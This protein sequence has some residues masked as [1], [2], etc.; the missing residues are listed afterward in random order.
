MQ[1]DCNNKH[2]VLV[3]NSID[4]LTKKQGKEI[5]NFDIVVRFGKGVP[6]GREE[7]IGSRTDIWATGS[8]RSKMR[9]HYPEDTKVLYNPSCFTY[10]E[11]YPH[12]EHTVMF[13]PDEL[14]YIHSDYLKSYTPNTDQRKRL[15]IGLLTALYFC[16]KVNT[17]ASLTFINFD[18]F[19]KGTKFKDEMHD[20]ESVAT[21]WH[22][23][24][25]V[26]QFED[27]EDALRNHPS[28]DSEQEKKIVQ[29]LLYNRNDIYFIGDIAPEYSYEDVSELAW[30]NY[31]KPI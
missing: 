13:T 19:H 12:Y 18:F 1:L 15:S 5:D 14:E 2:I 27:K 21:S 11:E 30:D 9:D 23:P 26:P 6:T 29:S 7:Y 22:L 3:G 8:L 10:L 24:L 28:H 20:K 4:S 17:F 31:R 16:T 25:A